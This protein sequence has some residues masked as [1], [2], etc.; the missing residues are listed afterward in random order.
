MADVCHSVCVCQV[1]VCTV[2]CPLC[3]VGVL[4]HVAVVSRGLGCTCGP[5]LVSLL[6]ITVKHCGCPLGVS[7]HMEQLSAALLFSH[8]CPFF[9]F[10]LHGSL[11]LAKVT[12]NC[13]L[14]STLLFRH[15]SVVVVTRLHS[16]I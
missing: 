3:D 8:C 6:Y 12:Q 1:G 11:E 5:P 4:L 13:M 14:K 16:I 7:S 2:I 15:Y 9:F 10:P